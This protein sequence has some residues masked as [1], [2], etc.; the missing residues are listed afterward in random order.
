[1]TPYRSHIPSLQFEIEYENEESVEELLGGVGQRVLDKVL[2]LANSVSKKENWPLTKIQLQRYVDIDVPG[3]EY[4]LIIMVFD[5]T[6]EIANSYLHEF[7]KHLDNLISQ[8]NEEEKA[9][10]YKFLY[11]DIETTD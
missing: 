3:W 8:L 6:F 9:V 10:M 1:M 4:V 7:Y 5:C 2:R 11:F